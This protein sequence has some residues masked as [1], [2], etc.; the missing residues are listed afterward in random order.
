M[1]T[2]SPLF[3]VKAAGHSDVG[4]VRENNEDAWKVIPEKNVY[5]LADGMGG[6]R[7]GEVAAQIAVD[8]Y[9][10][11]ITSRLDVEAIDISNARDL[12]NQIIVEVNQVVYQTARKDRE[13]RGMGTT[14][15]ALFFLPKTVVYA[16]VGDSRIYRFRD[17][18][19]LQFTEDHSLVQELLDLGE[20]SSRQAEGHRQRNIITKAIGTEPVIEPSLDSSDV[21]IGDL[22][23]LC[24]DGLT[25][26]LSNR[27]VEKILTLTAPL[28]QKVDLMIQ[29]ANR[30]GG[31]DNITVVLLEVIPNEKKRLS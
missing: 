24:S 27:E 15:C 21:E 23:L 13:F 8:S 4:L 14:L 19:L 22:F 9:T 11:L 7:A 29:S 1:V 20:L 31:Q 25:D 17:Q 2:K 6:H 26:L 28:A 5:V 18:K 10:D 16:H 30:R 3:T 12:L